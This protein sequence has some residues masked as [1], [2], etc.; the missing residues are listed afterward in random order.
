MILSVL[1]AFFIAKLKKYSLAPVFQSF[2]LY[3]LFAVE[4]LYWF[5][6]INTFM[7]NYDYIKFSSYLKNAYML[8]LLIPILIYKLYGAALVSSGCVLI[9]TVLNKIAIK[10]NDGKMP[11]YPTLSKLTGYYKADS[12]EDIAD[13]LHILGDLGVKLKILTD[14]IDIGWSILSI[15]DL[16]N[17]SFVTIIVFYT[18]KALNHDKINKLK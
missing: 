18:I 14:Y 9:G 8:V 6:Q 4:I 5:F 17:H 1:I 7:G 15:G 2:V 13:S 16:L 3:P 11:I 12:L 10:A